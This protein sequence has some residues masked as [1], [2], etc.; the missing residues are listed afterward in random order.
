[1]GPSMSPTMGAP[2]IV[3]MARIL[4]QDVS[5]KAHFPTR[6]PIQIAQSRYVNTTAAHAKVPESSSALPPSGLP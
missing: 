1:M 3:T 5:E 2:I 4:I 6:Q